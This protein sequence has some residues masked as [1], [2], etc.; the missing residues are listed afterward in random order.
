MELWIQGLSKT[1]PTPKKG[2]DAGKKISGI[3]I[4]IVT[5]TMGLP[6]AISVTMANISDR[7]AAV[8]MIET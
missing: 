1:L 4:H 6:H 3:K 7:E 8:D 2:Y 5:D